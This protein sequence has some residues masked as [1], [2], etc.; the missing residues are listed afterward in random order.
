MQ[1]YYTGDYHARR[2][3]EPEGR[4]NTKGGGCGGGAAPTDSPVG[5]FSGY[6]DPMQQQEQ[7]QQQRQAASVGDRPE[8]FG[9]G[10]DVGRSGIAGGGGASPRGG[11]GEGLWWTCG[12]W[13]I[14]GR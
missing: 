5:A 14:M 1:H 9:L 7:Q 11:S 4:C 13:S 6:D 3:C 12:A 8:G 10:R 2:P